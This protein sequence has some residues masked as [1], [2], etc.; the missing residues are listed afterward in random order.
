MKTIT[1][2]K[3]F[4]LQ[5][6]L[7]ITL[8]ITISLTARAGKQDRPVKNFSKIEISGAFEVTLTQ[9]SA[10]KLTIEADEN[11]LPKIITEVKGGTL[12]IR[13]ENNT[14]I[15]GDLKAYLTFINLD[16]IDIS[17]AVKLIG[18]APMK[19]SKLEIDGSGASKIDLDL[20]A[21]RVDGDFSGAS[22]I[23]LKGTATD[24]EIDLSGASDLEAVDFK[25]Q[26]CHLECSGAS[27][28][29]VFATGTLTV[30]GSGASQVSYAGNPASVNSDMSGASKFNKI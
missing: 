29:S 15:R 28:A 11:L 6:I 10:E 27:K 5:V 30:E 14:H 25:T 17:G 7:L 12:I 1:A 9:G 21:S 26:N 24:F 19:F 16:G 23:T 2:Q 4:L 8:A 13:I 3:N 22:E 20:S 18:S